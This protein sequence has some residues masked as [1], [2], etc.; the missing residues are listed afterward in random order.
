MI[1]ANEFWWDNI[2]G[3]RQFVTQVL[4]VLNSNKMALLEVPSDLPWRHTMRGEI[5]AR[6]REST[7]SLDVLID[8]IDAKDD[9][10]DED[11]GTF[12]LNR[13]AAFDP[14]I[15]DGFRETKSNTIQ[16]YLIKNEVLKNRIIWIKGINAEYAKRWIEFCENYVITDITQGCF[17]LEIQGSIPRDERSNVSIISYEGYVTRHDVQLFNAIY[18]DECEEVE[19]KWKTYISVLAA[20]ICDTDAEISQSFIESGDFK[21]ISPDITM[22]HIANDLIFERRGAEKDSRHILSSVRRGELDEMH[23]RIWKAQIQTLFPIIEFERVQL[24]TK[25]EINISEALMNN[26]VMQYDVQITNPYDAELGTLFYLNTH[27]DSL[28]QY[29]LYIPDATDRARIDFLHT[30]RNLLAHINICSPEQVCELLGE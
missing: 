19:E 28:G 15:R 3:P 10:F 8:A 30:C 12:L 24:I 9:I 4:N 16:K 14:A 18:L 27:R 26:R 1:N 2:T 7:N 23:N 29:K 25:W 11:P 20:C 5:E 21:R 6:F 17:V 13:Y 22:Q